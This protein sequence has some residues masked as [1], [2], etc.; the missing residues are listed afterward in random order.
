MS[1]GTT[2]LGNDILD[3]EH[4]AGISICSSN[5]ILGLLSREMLAYAAQKLVYECS[6][7]HYCVCVCVC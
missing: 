1:P 2:G 5:S 6:Q 4:K 3:G 7:K